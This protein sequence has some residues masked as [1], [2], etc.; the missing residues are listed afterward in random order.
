MV[1]DF[2]GLRTVKG[3]GLRVVGIK[4]FRFMLLNF[5]VYVGVEACFSRAMKHFLK[6]F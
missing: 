2:G 3:L 5:K 6:V 1:Q 4:G